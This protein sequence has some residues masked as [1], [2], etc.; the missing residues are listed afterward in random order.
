MSKLKSLCTGVVYPHW[1]YTRIRF[2]SLF[3]FFL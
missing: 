1:K 3:L 2:W